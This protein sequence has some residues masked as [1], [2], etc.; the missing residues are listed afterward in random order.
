MSEKDEKSR[1]MDYS[2]KTYGDGEPSTVLQLRD[3]LEDPYEQVTNR[4]SNAQFVLYN[5][6]QYNVH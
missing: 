2:G 3:W 6:Y 4:V 1:L 5:V